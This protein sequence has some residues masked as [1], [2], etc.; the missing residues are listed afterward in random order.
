MKKDKAPWLLIQTTGISLS[1]EQCLAFS[2]IVISNYYHFK[3]LADDSIE[4]GRAHVNSSHITISYAV[5]CLKKKK[6]KKTKQKNK[7]KIINTQYKQTTKT[8]D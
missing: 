3:S 2:E 1:T 4:I 5:F 6:K 7:K 8:Q